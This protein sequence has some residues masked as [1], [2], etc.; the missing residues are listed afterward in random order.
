MIAKAVKG[1]AS[2]H[3]DRVC[4]VL[5]LEIQLAHVQLLLIKHNT[6]IHPYLKSINSLLFRTV[7][8][9]RAAV[10]EQVKPYEPLA[11]EKKNKTQPRFHST[12]KKPGRKHKGNVLKRV[13]NINLIITSCLITA[14]PYNLGMQAS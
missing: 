4:T 5:S 14:V 2:Q 9:T 7:T 8:T 1:H 10:E 11:P 6:V 3:K 12:C 13:C